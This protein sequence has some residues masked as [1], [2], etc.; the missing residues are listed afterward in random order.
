MN[1]NMSAKLRKTI[2][3]EKKIY[4]LVFAIVPFITKASDTTLTK[5]HY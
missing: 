3:I 5:K 4:Y 1:I 2:G